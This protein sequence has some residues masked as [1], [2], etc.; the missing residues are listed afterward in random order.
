M[1]NGKH[2][3]LLPFVSDLLLP[4]L[5]S[6]LLDILDFC[7]LGFCF[8]FCVFISFLRLFVCFLPLHSLILF[9]KH[10]LP[11]FFAGNMEKHYG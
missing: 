5:L 4:A 7:L 1:G 2:S 8:H 10:S 3:T 6:F 9:R 11:H